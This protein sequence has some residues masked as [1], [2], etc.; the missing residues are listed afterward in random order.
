MEFKPNIS[1]I[2]IQLTLSIKPSL[3]AF[4]ISYYTLPSLF[5]CIFPHSF[6]Q[7]RA[8]L[9]RDQMAQSGPNWLRLDLRD[10]SSVGLPH[11]L[12]PPVCTT[13]TIDIAFLHAQHCQAVSQMNTACSLSRTNEFDNA[14]HGVEFMSHSALLV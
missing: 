12:S 3:S 5:L 9:R 7:A 4:E 10:R 11:Q 13:V 2:R 6:I 14:Q 1:F 8:F